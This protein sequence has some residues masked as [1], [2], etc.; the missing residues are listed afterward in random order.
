L[1]VIKSTA[2]NH[3]GR[4]NGFTVPNLSAQAELFEENFKKS[5]IDPRT[6]SY[7]EAAA[8]GSAL[9]DPIEVAALTKALASLPRISSFVQSDR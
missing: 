3:G 9:G 6:I 4:S 2:T 1:A 8:N 7:V 5:G